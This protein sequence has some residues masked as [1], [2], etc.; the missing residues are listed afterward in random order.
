M[1]LLASWT[2]AVC[3]KHNTGLHRKC[4]RCSMARGTD[5][6]AV[7]QVV[8]TYRQL[9]TGNAFKRDAADMAAHGWRV[10]SQSQA[11]IGLGHNIKETNVVYERD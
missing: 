3:G 4:G 1:S 6:A 9:A 7:R 2:R 10:Q 11:N 5:G 8:V